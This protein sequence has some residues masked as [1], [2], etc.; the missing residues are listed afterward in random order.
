MMYAYFSIYLLKI[1]FF[2]FD[3]PVFFI[4]EQMLDK[5]RDK[6]KNAL[7]LRD[8]LDCQTLKILP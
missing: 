4:T 1:K 6:F 7:V 8:I 3:T 2:Q 5:F